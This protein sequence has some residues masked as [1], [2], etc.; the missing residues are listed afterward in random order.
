M[1]R[2]ITVHTE[3]EYNVIIGKNL[4]VPSFAKIEELAQNLAL[5]NGKTVESEFKKL[6]KQKVLISGFPFL[7]SIG[8]MGF[9]VAGV[10][11]VFTR[12]RYNK[13]KEQ[14]AQN[15]NFVAKKNYTPTFKQFVA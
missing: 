3:P 6:A 9:F 15:N 8:F 1:K 5:K 4:E 11:N 10:S 7:F 2:M 12:Y 14:Q 13:D